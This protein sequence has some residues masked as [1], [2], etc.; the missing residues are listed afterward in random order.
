MS[1]FV[2]K[3]IALTLCIALIFSIEIYQD[4]NSNTKVVADEIE[5]FNEDTALSEAGNHQNTEEEN[6]VYIEETAEVVTTEP[7][8][9]EAMIECD[10]PDLVII[11]KRNYPYNWEAVKPEITLSYQG[12]LLEEGQDFE[13]VK[14]SYENNI[15]V[16]VVHATVKGINDYEG[17][18]EEEIEYEIVPKNIADEDVII[19]NK[20]LKEPLEFNGKDRTPIVKLSYN[21]R[22]LLL[23]ADYFTDYQ[24][25]FYPGTASVIITGLDNFTGEVIETFKIVKRHIGNVTIRTSFDANNKLVVAVNNGSYSM[26]YGTDY[27]YTVYTDSVGNITITFTGLGENYTGTF[28]KRIEAADNPAAIYM[29][30]T[31]APTVG[32]EEVKIKKVKN[33]KKYKAKLSWKKLSGVSGY[34]LRYA[35]NSI[36]KKAVVKNIKKSK[37]EYT[38]SKLELKKKY[39][40]S[41]RAYRIVNN[42]TYYGKWSK[43]EKVKIKK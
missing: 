24:D 28:V 12:V 32:V 22:E 30:T 13:F 29:T 16:G 37:A 19:D 26:T 9:T 3:C 4:K 35:D 10:N 39:Y 25:F 40:F 33:V 21:N 38:I 36:F 23:I 18:F 14:E 34:Q 31:P 41:I 7:E 43:K 20:N 8:T 15:K 5:S 2:K 11:G 42:V 6:S 17:M 27:T 1:A